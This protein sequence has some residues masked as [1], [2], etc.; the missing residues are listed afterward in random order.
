MKIF[1]IA[2]APAY[3]LSAAGTVPAAARPSCVHPVADMPR[4][5]GTRPAG[6]AREAR[7]LTPVVV[8]RRRAAE[9]W[10][11]VPVFG[12]VTASAKSV[13]RQNFGQVCVPLSVSERSP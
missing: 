4:V 8:R 5:A 11:A 10:R 9:A 6:G 7:P 2:G 12:A 13:D 3:L 1:A